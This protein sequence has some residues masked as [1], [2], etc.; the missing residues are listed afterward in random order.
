VP[1][2]TLTIARIMTSISPEDL[3]ALCIAAVTRCGGDLATA[4]S[5]ARATVDAERRGKGVVGVSHLFDYLSGIRERR[6]AG[7]PRPEIRTPRGAVV[8]VDADHGIAQLSFDLAEDGLVSAAETVGLAVLSMHQSF[9]VG[10]LG[11]YTARLA[12]RGL[13]ALACANS[14]AAVSIQNS[15]D[16][17]T[18]TNPF[19]FAIPGR[20]GQVHLLDQ[21]SSQ[22]A[23]VRVRAAAAAGKAIPEGWAIDSQGLPTTDPAVALLGTLLPFGGIKGSNVA[24][25][26]EMLSVLSGAQFSLDQG[27]SSHRKESDHRGEHPNAGLFILALDPHVFDPDYLDRVNHYLERLKTTHGISFGTGRPLLNLIEIPDLLLSQLVEAAGGP[28]LP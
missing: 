14:P 18:G 3:R 7:S 24:L 1:A 10:E 19:S 2:T 13:L 26:I 23:W 11:A 4:K 17:V 28:T 6:I 21:A 22:A 16:P 20:S 27:G 5:L 25:S 8:V 12:Q 15:L 9:T